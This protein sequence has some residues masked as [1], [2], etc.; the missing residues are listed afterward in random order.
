MGRSIGRRTARVVL[1]TLA[2]GAGLAPMAVVA[3][4]SGAP[5][6]D[7]SQAATRVQLTAS[8]DLDPTCTYTAGFDI[9]ASNVTLDCKGAAIHGAIDAAG[10]GIQVSTPS[11]TELAHVVVRN[12]HVSGFLNSLRVTRPGFRTLTAG[13][14]YDHPTSDI[15]IEDST[16][17][18]SRGVGVYVDGYVTGVTIRRNSITHAGSSGIYL[19]GGSKGS[20]VVGNEID[21]NGFRENGPDGQT[22]DIGGTTFWYWGVG[23]EGISVDGSSENHI[24]DNHLTGNSAGGIFLYKNCGEYPNSGR[25]FERRTPSDRNLIEANVFEGGRNG[26]WVGSRMAENTLPMACTDPAYIDEAARRVV[27]DHAAHN[28]ISGNSFRNVTYGIRVEDDDTT[29]AGN[30]FAGSAPD[31]HAIIVG[32][33]LRAEVLHRPVLDTVLRDNVSTIVGNANPYRTIPGEV[34]TAASGNVALGQAVG[35]CAGV[36]LPRQTFI[37]VIAVKADDGSGTKPPTPDLRVPTV[38]ALPAC[39]KAGGGSTTTTS[40]T[41]PTTGPLPGDAAPA[42]PIPGTA[43]FTG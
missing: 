39:A 23:R 10:V 30:A 33:P 13:H 20:E 27:L 28:T 7:C 9:T 21:D 24:A 40:T 8:A 4:A 17:T 19:E 43:S 18:G 35:V 29:V 25:Y 36:P 6:V 12:C 3:P 34:G 31:H 11:D 14:E 5:I 38:G 2:L 41:E 37:F 15:V 22:I 42:T 26:V 32:T 1:A 16:F